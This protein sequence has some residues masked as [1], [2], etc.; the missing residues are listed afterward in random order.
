MKDKPNALLAL[1]ISLKFPNPASPAQAP[2]LLGHAVTLSFVC[3]HQRSRV[4]LR[5][6]T[7]AQTLKMFAV[8]GTCTHHPRPSS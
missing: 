7:Q 6:T 8:S 2:P 5:I 3:S 1:P 4:L